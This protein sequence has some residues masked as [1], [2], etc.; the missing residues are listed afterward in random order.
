M[1]M[2]AK[3]I[4]VMIRKSIDFFV[5]WLIS[6]SEIFKVEVDRF[7]TIGCLSIILVLQNGGSV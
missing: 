7:F 1:T 6:L 4:E 2:M 5:A 3:T